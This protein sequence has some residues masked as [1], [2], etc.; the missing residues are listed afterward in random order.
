MGG[1]IATL[2]LDRP[3]SLNAASQ[4]M[5]QSLE[6]RLRSLASL[7]DLRAVI[8][9]G[10]GR[11]FCAGGDLL[12]FEAALKAGGTTLID[13]LRYNQDVIQMVEDLPVPV[14][15][16]VNGV[17]VAGGLELLLACDIIV[18]ADG[19]KIG[20]GH[21]KYGVV[22]AGGATVRLSERIGPSRAAQ[23]FYTASLADARTLME[24]GIVNEVVPKGDLMERTLELAREICQRSPEANRHIK[25]LTGHMARAEERTARIRREL[26]RF[27]QHIHGADLAN[28]LAAFR[29]K[30]NPDY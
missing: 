21:S 9:T 6:R 16:A 13:T 12:E 3:E 20:D 19:A 8:L 1:G 2:T 23:L 5:M 24:W 29:A 25:A 11:A 27:E 17:A 10:A 14:I 26:D 7:P 28:G 22:P 30:R 15:G 18:A 4:E